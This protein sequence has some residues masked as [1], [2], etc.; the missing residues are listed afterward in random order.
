MD[1]LA[2]LARAFHRS[3]DR[4]DARSASAA[5]RRAHAERAIDRYLAWCGGHVEALTRKSAREAAAFAATGAPAAEIPF[6]PVDLKGDNTQAVLWHYQAWLHQLRA[7]GL[8][9]GQVA[10]KRQ[11]ADGSWERLDLP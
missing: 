7:Q 1:P 5:E 10:L 9:G 3:R 11:R 2:P 6:G 8:Y 4:L